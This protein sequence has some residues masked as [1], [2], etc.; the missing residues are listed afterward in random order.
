M[1]H[2]AEIDSNNKVLKV[3][4]ACNQDI[5]N[6]GGEQSTQAAKHFES[7]VPLSSNGV[8]WVQTSYNNNFRKKFAGVGDTYDPV[9]DIFWNE[10]SPYSSWTLDL[11]YDW[12]PPVAK[13][14]KNTW[15]PNNAPLFVKWSEEK[16][17]WVANGYQIEPSTIENPGIIT[18][19]VWNNTTKD[20][21]LA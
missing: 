16:L 1:A 5:A 20:W 14:L 2:F 9:K 11:N 6:N 13:P 4:V 19:L 8:A 15:G 17:N 10:N 12:Q 21:D 7:V 3:I 18:P